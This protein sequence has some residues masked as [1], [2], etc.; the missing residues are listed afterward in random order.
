MFGP[1][2]NAHNSGGEKPGK[3]LS[4]DGGIHV[5]CNDGTVIISVV[6]PSGRSRMTASEWARG[7]GISVGD[8]LGE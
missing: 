2:P 3:V 4:T 1:K 6:Q 7:R 8:I 5:A